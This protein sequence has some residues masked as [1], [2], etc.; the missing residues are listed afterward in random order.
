MIIKLSGKDE[1]NEG[2]N[3]KKY[4]CKINIFSNGKYICS[5]CSN[6]GSGSKEE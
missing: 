5:M 1:I 6:C 3:A 2:E 4:I